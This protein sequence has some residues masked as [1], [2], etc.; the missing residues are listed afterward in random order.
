MNTDDVDAL[1]EGLRP[2]LGEM[3]RI[4]DLDQE[5]ADCCEQM[6]ADRERAERGRPS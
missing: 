5:I 6:F 4:V 1:R 2:A 3:G